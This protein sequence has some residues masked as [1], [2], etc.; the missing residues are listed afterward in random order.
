[1]ATIRIVTTEHLL[2]SLTKAAQQAVD[3]LKAALTSETPEQIAT[4]IKRRTEEV[5]SMKEVAA[6]AATH[7]K[8]DC[9]G[10]KEVYGP[11]CPG[12]DV[13]DMISGMD[14]TQAQL[15]AA[16]L[17][18]L[19]GD[20]LVKEDGAKVQE[21]AEEAKAEAVPDND[22]MPDHPRTCGCRDNTENRWADTKGRSE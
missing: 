9:Y 1:M 3:E 18:R 8:E 22:P 13:A 15:T 4:R 21:Q 5:A 10:C 17:L 16:M 7:D 6:I 19:L 11:G 14:E 20:A 12:V 2:E